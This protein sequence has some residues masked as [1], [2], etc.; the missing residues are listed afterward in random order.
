MGNILI[1]MSFV[2]LNGLAKEDEI[3][4]IAASETVTLST[5]VPHIESSMKDAAP[6]RLSIF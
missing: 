5:Y 4:K 6:D 1:Y 3:T 2:S